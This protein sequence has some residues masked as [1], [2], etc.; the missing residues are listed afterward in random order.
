MVSE[1]D[2]D[3]VYALAGRFENL[4]FSFWVGPSAS[5]A[6]SFDLRLKMAMVDSGAKPLP[7]LQDDRGGWDA[8]RWQKAKEML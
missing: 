2:G 3:V 6:L 4:T 8:K 7:M 1:G 5:G